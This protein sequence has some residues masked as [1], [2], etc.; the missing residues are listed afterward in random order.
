M[1]YCMFI[2]I[3]NISKL[4]FILAWIELGSGA[5]VASEFGISDLE[6]LTIH[7]EFF[8]SNTVINPLHHSDITVVI[9]FD[10]NH[11]PILYFV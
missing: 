10:D 6:D 4:H 2:Y 7:R 1:F 3:V 5:L 11:L 8:S 9:T